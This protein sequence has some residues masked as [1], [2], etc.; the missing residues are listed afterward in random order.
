MTAALRGQHLTRIREVLKANPDGLLV[1]E[2]AEAVGI[3]S[4][5]VWRQLKKPEVTWAYVD[6]WDVVAP[7]SGWCAVWCYAAPPEHCP[8]PTKPAAE[9]WREQKEAA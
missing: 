4:P 1:S 9:A 7:M 8:E 6:R 3:S 5:H 2:I